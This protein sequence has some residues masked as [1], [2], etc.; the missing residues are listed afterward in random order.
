MAQGMGD[1]RAATPMDR[2]EHGQRAAGA[3]GL[4]DR[5]VTEQQLAAWL[6]ASRKDVEHVTVTLLDRPATTGFSSETILFDAAWRKGSLVSKGQYVARVR[7]AT[8]RLYREYDL[9]VQWR[10]MDSLNRR[11]GLPVP[12][13]LGH[14]DSEDSVLGQPFFVMERIEG[15]APSD[16]PPF[17]IT[18][19]VADATS[20]QREAL[21][22]SGLE[23]LAAIHQVDWRGLGLSFLAHSPANPS[24]VGP[25]LAHDAEFLDWVA[26]GRG[27]P[28]FDQALEWM[29]RHVPADRP[30]VLS[31]GDARLG[32]MLFSDFRPVAV[33]DWEMVTLAAPASDLG[34]WIVFDRLHTDAIGRSRPTGMLDERET[35]AWYEHLTGQTVRD[36]MFYKVRAA[37]RAGLLLRRFTD[38]LVARGV[39]A[40]DATRGPYTP[41]VNVLTD[42]LHH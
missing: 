10:V 11:T 29:D 28:V 36:L 7:P 25:A 17:T 34:W 22:R 33:L 4:R 8:H 18:G 31:W 14:D 26:G 30:P 1:S 3:T 27:L 2:E 24:G 12:G 37:F 16:S 39:M 19:W 21:H 15:R 32:N 40:P 41:A 5:A 42:L 13:I 38:F 20:A 35:V 23:V 9:E 6:L